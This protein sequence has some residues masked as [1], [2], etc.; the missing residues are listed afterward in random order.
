MLNWLR[1]IK[2]RSDASVTL[3]AR[4][5]ALSTLLDTVDSLSRDMKSI[6]LE[7]EETFESINRALRKLAQ[8]QKRAEKDCGCSDEPSEGE[9]TRPGNG[10]AD[11]AQMLARIRAQRGG[12]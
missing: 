12:W 4:E 7:W 8:R 11:D 3:S 5:E 1:S 10:H 2:G 6:K 9:T